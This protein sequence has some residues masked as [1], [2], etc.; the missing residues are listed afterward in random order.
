MMNNLDLKRATF[1]AIIVWC[2][3]VTAFISSYY[4]PVMED[5]DAQANLVLSIVLIPATA[6]GAHFYYRKGHNTR[7]FLL[8]ASMFLVTMILDACITVPVFMIPAGIN[9]LAFFGDPGFW[10]IGLE[11]ICVVASYW[12]LSQIRHGARMTH[13]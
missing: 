5:L 4:V 12:R 7:G 2:L 1:S 8:G 3:G 13:S 6:F 10:I 11:Y 9:H